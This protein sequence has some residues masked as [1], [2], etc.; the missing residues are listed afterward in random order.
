MF[1]QRKTRERCLANERALY[2][3]NRALERGDI[4]TIALL[5][6][7]ASQNEELERMI[8][9]MH[10]LDQPVEQSPAFASE[11]HIP[12]TYPLEP[13]LRSNPEHS[14]RQQWARLRFQTL[15]AVLVVAA[16]IAGSVLLFTSRHL[17]PAPGSLASTPSPTKAVVVAQGM[18][19]LLFTNGDV[20]AVRGGTGQSVWSY[21]TG[22]NGLGD[23]NLPAY[24]GLIVQNQ[25]VY[26]MAKNHI[27]V[28]NE[29]TGGLLWQK[30]LPAQLENITPNE[31]QMLLDGSILYVS[32]EST[33]QSVAYALRASDGQILWQVASTDVNPPL[34]TASN[35]I[36][37]VA[38]QN[39]AMT[40]T[41]MQAR[42][43]SD[44]HVLWSYTSPGAISFA[45][46]ANQVLYVY[47]F[48]GAVPY[49]CCTKLDK[50]LLAFKTSNGDLIWSR[51]VH[52]GNYI[53]NIAYAQ[54]VLI[55]SDS[56]AQICAHSTSNGALLWCVPKQ[57]DFSGSSG[58]GIASYLVGPDK[59]YVALVT[60]RSIPLSPTE[61]VAYCHQ[62]QSCIDSA[63]KNHMS[64]VQSSLQIESLDLQ[65]G[66]PQW[67]NNRLAYPDTLD[68]SLSLGL[69]QLQQGT[70]LVSTGSVLV[71]A[72][73]TNSGH[74][75]W[76]INGSA[77][78]SSVLQIAGTP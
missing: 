46:A 77:P 2:R 74:K 1:E 56:Y 23:P 51:D 20:Q 36:A 45:T 25:A 64:N 4:E 71:T 34:L 58:V 70:L 17:A 35:G 12:V 31:S 9:A 60:Q 57:A 75:L 5:L 32:L 29:K 78:Q 43:G 14:T 76:Q 53:A 66:Q 8:Y 41:T 27:V 3:Y 21:A 22:Q 61:I 37:Y 40:Q 68:A 52:Y 10:E 38:I 72:L 30:K 42:R 26:V 55:V 65:S 13:V 50:R 62:Q 7:E 67:T 24:R 63:Q 44:G 6:Q 28:L 33:P 16:L 73:D 18:V 19:I 39:A 69:V 11:H 59:L 49:N 47:A 15:A 54:G 48:P